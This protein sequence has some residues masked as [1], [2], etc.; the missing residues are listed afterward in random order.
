ML[1]PASWG[2]TSPDQASHIRHSFNV[3]TPPSA[4]RASRM[5]SDEKDRSRRHSAFVEKAKLVSVCA[6]TNNIFAGLEF[7]IQYPCLSFVAQLFHALGAEGGEQGKWVIKATSSQPGFPKAKYM[8]KI[9]VA[10]WEKTL[11]PAQLLRLIMD[12]PWAS[13]A[14]VCMK[15]LV[16]V[17]KVLQQ[18]PP[19]M[20]RSYLA[21]VGFLEEV[22]TTWGNVGGASPQGTP[23]CDTH[24]VLP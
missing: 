4:F 19:A 15:M 12:R 8:R 7:L 23:L 17:L 6:C 24:D 10:I 5:H 16:L 1:S 9:V 3:P 21:Y 20:L 22:S 2:P 14:C 18:G 13:D 11:S